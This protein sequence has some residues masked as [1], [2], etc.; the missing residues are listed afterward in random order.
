[1]HE[2]LHTRKTTRAV[3]MAGNAIHTARVVQSS[4]VETEEGYMY[5]LQNNRS[6]CT[7]AWTDTI[8]I[9]FDT[10]FCIWILQT[11]LVG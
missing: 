9:N 11:S 1:M 3:Q 4:V 6:Q 10:L 7:V 2:L 5:N 8:L